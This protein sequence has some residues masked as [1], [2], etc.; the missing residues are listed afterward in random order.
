MADL[1]V[2]RIV[3]DYLSANGYDGLAGDECGCELSDLFPCDCDGGDCQP[4]YRWTCDTCELAPS[5]EAHSDGADYCV[6][7]TKQ[8]VYS[9]ANG[10]GA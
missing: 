9:T 5:C 8:D 2:Y 6:C 10:E 1:T 4:G 7:T 3:H